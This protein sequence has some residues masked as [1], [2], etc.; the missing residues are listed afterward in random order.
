MLAIRGVPGASAPILGTPSKEDLRMDGKRKTRSFQVWPVGTWSAKMEFYANLRLE[1]IREGKDEDPLGSV[2]FSTAHDENYLKQVTAESLVTRTKHGKTKTEWE[3][4]G[5]NHFLD[6][7]VYS[8]AA[9]EHLALSR[10]TLDEWEK[11]AKIRNIADDNAQGDLL[12]LSTELSA[13]QPASRS[14]S[15]KTGE[16]SNPSAGQAARPPA[17]APADVPPATPPAEPKPSN[18]MAKMKKPRRRFG[19]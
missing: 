9:A 4:S 3:T 10:L 19:Y 14:S 11:L 12:S 8:R 15:G 6:C 1:G 7:K 2:F 17:Q 13:A 18:G 5:P 16:G